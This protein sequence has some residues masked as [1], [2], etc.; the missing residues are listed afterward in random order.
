[1]SSTR[2]AIQAWDVGGTAPTSLVNVTCISRKCLE[3][4][5][6]DGGLLARDQ[7]GEW[8]R[9]LP[10]APDSPG[11]FALWDGTSAWPSIWRFAPDILSARSL[12]LAAIDMKLL[13]II[14]NEISGCELKLQIESFKLG[15]RALARN[16]TNHLVCMNCILFTLIWSPFICHQWGILHRHGDTSNL[17]KGSHL[18]LWTTRFWQFKGWSWSVTAPATKPDPQNSSTLYQAHPGMPE[19][20]QGAQGC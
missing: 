6:L 18:P 1:M 16:K 4:G 11:F 14:F 2:G 19:M 7:D 17:G 15:A 8:E 12:D 20:W 9:E 10:N 3:L 13:F 5:W